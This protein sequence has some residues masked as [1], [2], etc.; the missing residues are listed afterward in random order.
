MT[1]S[2]EKLLSIY[3]E[4]KAKRIV[5]N[6]DEFAQAVGKSRAH[7]FKKMVEIPKDIIDRAQKLLATGNVANNTHSVISK[8]GD[9]G[10]E[11]ERL[12]QLSIQHEA[13]LDV[14]QLLIESILGDLKGKSIA[15]ISAEIQEAIKRRADILF[16]EYSKKR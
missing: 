6:Q 7:L 15:I 1:A 4:C 8:E 3:E 9:A 10:K 2:K 11:L 5:L 14:F 12:I 16:D 13:K